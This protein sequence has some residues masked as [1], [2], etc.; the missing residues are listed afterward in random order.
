MP[1][2][3]PTF[4]VGA[5]VAMLARTMWRSAAAAVTGAVAA[6]APHAMATMRPT[7]GVGAGVAVLARTMWRSAAAAVT[8]AVAALAQHAMATMS[9][10]RR[11]IADAR[12]G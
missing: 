9:P 4:G 11:L 7:F 10:Q 2:T 6:L 12:V 5:G 3:Q 1:V 8:G